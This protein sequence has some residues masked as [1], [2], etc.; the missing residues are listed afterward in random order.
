MELRMIKK[1][2][3]DLTPW[4]ILFV[5]TILVSV[6]TETATGA[7]TIQKFTGIARNKDGQLEYVEKHQIT[8]QDGKVISSFTNYFDPQD[9]YIGDLK[10][11]YDAGYQYGSYV[12][13]DSRGGLLNGATVKDDYV[14]IY[15]QKDGS[16]TVTTK[17]I[18]RA[19]NQIVGQGFHHFIVNNLETIDTGRIM[20]VRMV[21]PA[22][23]DDY[24]F[25]I[26]KIKREG[27]IITI[28]LEI[29]NWFL[30]L[31][32]PHIDTDYHLP[33]KRLLRY[34]GISNLK[35]V[36]GDYKDVIIEYSYDA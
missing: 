4:Y 9:H 1:Y 27:N 5:T 2:L 34:K 19:A 18:P 26:R 36:S 28:R 17:D 35:D 33:S 11:R 29:D 10:S 15:S 21:L 20:R 23:L 30:R 22:Q 3:F 25:L 16:S 12:F 31:F 13:T 7:V 32:A 24:K 8:Y 14:R 6:L